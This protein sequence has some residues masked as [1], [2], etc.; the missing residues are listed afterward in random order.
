MRIDRGYWRML[1]QLYITLI[2]RR[3]WV[4]VHEA[5]VEICDFREGI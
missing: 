1:R 3:W 5:N 4:R 2:G